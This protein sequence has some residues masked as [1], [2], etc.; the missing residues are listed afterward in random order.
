MRIAPQG[1][2]HGAALAMLLI[3]TGELTSTDLQRL[4]QPLPPT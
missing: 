4:P 2:G 3:S 1:T